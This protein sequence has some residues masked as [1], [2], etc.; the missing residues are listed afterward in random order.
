MFTALFILVVGFTVIPFAINSM[1]MYLEDVRPS[2]VIAGAV[3][4]VVVFIATMLYRACRFTA[5]RVAAI[6]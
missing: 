2:R 3:V 5:R 6:A 4:S 1:V